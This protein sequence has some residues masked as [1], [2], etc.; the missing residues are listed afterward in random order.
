MRLPIRMVFWERLPADDLR[1]A[2]LSQHWV[3]SALTRVPATVV[4]P[5]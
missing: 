5:I 2:E 4:Q 3:F 1:K